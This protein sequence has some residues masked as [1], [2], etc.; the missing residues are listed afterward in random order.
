MTK[1]EVEQRL[2]VLG[3]FWLSDW[4]DLHQLWGTA[5]GFEIMVPIAGPHSELDERDLVEIELEIRRSK[6]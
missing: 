1:R 4:D 3:A 5:W 6:P 2:T